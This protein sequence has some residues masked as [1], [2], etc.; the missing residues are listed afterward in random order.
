MAPPGKM[1]D[2]AIICALPREFDAVEAV[3]DETYS[4]ATTVLHHG[5]A[6]FYT[7]GRIQDRQVVIVCLPDMGK[8][9]AASAAAS[10]CSSFPDIVLTFLVGICGGVPFPSEGI[11]LILGDVII[12][13]HVCNYDFGK[14][15]PDGFERTKTIKE[16]LD[17]S[18]TKVIS[19]L[20]G[21]RTRRTR[22]RFQ[23]KQRH[24]L[25]RLQQS[26]VWH[27]QPDN[28][29]SANCSGQ[30]VARKRLSTMPGYA[31]RPFVHLGTIASGDTVMKSGDHRD[32]LAREQGVIG[33]EMEGAGVCESLSCI[34]VKGVCD[35]ADSHKNKIWQDYAAASAAC[36]TRTLIQWYSSMRELRPLGITQTVLSIQKPE[37]RSGNTYSTN[38]IQYIPGSIEQDVENETTRMRTLFGT[39]YSR[40]KASFREGSRAEETT[41]WVAFR[42]APWLRRLGLNYGVNATYY[43]HP[44]VW[45]FTLQPFRTVSDNSIVFSFCQDG[46]IGAVSRLIERGEASVYDTDSTGWSPLHIAIGCGQFELA[47]YL[48]MEGADR[49]AH[50]H[51][52]KCSNHYKPVTFFKEASFGEATLSLQS[53]FGHCIYFY[54]PHPGGW[55]WLGTLKDNSTTEQLTSL[56]VT[57]IYSGTP[58]PVLLRTLP[59]EPLGNKNREKLWYA[60]RQACWRKDIQTI[61]KCLNLVPR[62]Q[63][64]AL[65][66]SGTT[67]FGTFA[68]YMSSGFLVLQMLLD[69]GVEMRI[70]FGGE[71]PTSRAMRLSAMFFEW[72]SEVALLYDSTDMLIWENVT[73]RRAPSLAGWT[74]RTLRD[75]FALKPVTNGSGSGEEDWSP[76]IFYEKIRCRS[77]KT[78]RRACNTGEDGLM[79]EPWWESVKERI[80]TGQCCCSMSEWIH[81]NRDK[82]SILHGNC[83]HKI[84]T[85]TTNEPGSVSQ[86]SYN[87]TAAA[88]ISGILLHNIPPPPTLLSRRVN[89]LQVSTGPRPRDQHSLPLTAGSGAG[90]GHRKGQKLVDRAQAPKDEAQEDTDSDHPKSISSFAA[91]IEHFYRRQGG[92]KSLYRPEEYYCFSCLALK[93]EWDLA[94]LLNQTRSDSTEPF[95][96]T[97]FL[98][99]AVA[100]GN[101]ATAVEQSNFEEHVLDPFGID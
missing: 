100:L 87:Q 93:E 35:Y 62:Q 10:L 83:R 51:H 49:L 66:V 54:E 98:N 47:K 77:C 60:L 28:C 72:C 78:S 19:L 68:D 33:F 26:T 23:K 99:Q 24:F 42:P 20:A 86:S 92:W 46:N 67:S 4:D 44:S 75:L 32:A 48:L 61:K 18:N 70:Q 25:R 27:Y 82:Q 9:R 21:L 12:S 31:P 96:P 11:E 6:N 89:R 59:S 55:M 85:T 15:Y 13:R 7:T 50:A 84:Q 56:C 69:K 2:V 34:I 63:D 1:I 41:T 52:I 81:D 16:T 22:E 30:T 17:R 74:S 38:H 5:D 64:Y 40:R 29:D 57:D 73:G 14:Q 58:N 43:V 37:E 36:S 53:L 88:S 45:Q 76:Y 91:I 8:A 101:I 80:K 65:L 97:T 94:P 39:V 90:Q 71:T 79:I 3:L 95:N